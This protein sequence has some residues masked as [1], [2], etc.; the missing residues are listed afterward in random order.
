M[1]NCQQILSE[2]FH[3]KDSDIQKLLSTKALYEEW[4]AQ[5][6]VISRKDMEHFYEHHLI[7][8][9]SIALFTKFTPGTKLIDV[10]TGGGFPGIPLA[11]LFPECEFVLNDSIGKKLKVA[12]AVAAEL[13]LKNIKTVHGRSE[14]VKDKFDVVL[15]RAVKNIPEFYQFTQ[16]LLDKNGEYWYLK[17]GDFDEELVSVPLHAKV[18]SIYSKIKS[19][20]YETKKVVHMWK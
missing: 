11:V 16:H 12:N 17:G 7:H 9:L 6:N 15:G 3:L 1:F 20:F 8:S 19:D 10:G 14:D 2:Q 5:I 18:Y 13:G 4:N